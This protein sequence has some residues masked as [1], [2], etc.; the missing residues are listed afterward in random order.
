VPALT[1]LSAREHAE[2]MAA[3]EERRSLV[4]SYLD[5]WPGAADFKPLEID[6]AIYSYVRR[7]GKALRPLVLLLCCGA[8]GGDEAQALPAAAAVEVFHTWTLVH[9]DVIDRDDLR[10][11]SPTVHAQFAE[12]ARQRGLSGAEA[13]HYGRT[14]AILAGDSQQSWSYA[15]LSSLRKRGVASDL[16]LELIERMATWLTPRLLEGEML[17]VQYS[18]SP[19]DSVSEAQV[20]DMLTKKTG[21][22]LEYAA[23]SGAR[24]GLAGFED[25]GGIADRLGQFASLCGTA[26]QLHDDLLGLTADEQILGKPVGSDLRE[27]KRTLIVHRALGVANEKGRQAILSVLGDSNASA[28]RITGALEAIASTDAISYV[29]DLANSY[30]SQAGKLLATLPETPQRGLLTSWASFLLARQH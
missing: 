7:R 17:D 21:A 3:L 5:A 8:V 20:V 27:G 18:L 19:L 14:V 2:F 13:E 28:S 1:T 12:Q 25:S 22:L 9:D 30:I 4:Y 23:W 24:I 15:L 26:F 29:S 16:V 11:G 6:E 10:R